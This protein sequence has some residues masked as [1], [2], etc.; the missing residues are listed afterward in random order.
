MEVEYA[1][2]IIYKKHG[3]AGKRGKEKVNMT[4]HVPKNIS[5]FPF[6][7]FLFIIFLKL[8]CKVSI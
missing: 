2:K 3:Q 6:L 4:L 8:K 1:V 7:H 5:Y